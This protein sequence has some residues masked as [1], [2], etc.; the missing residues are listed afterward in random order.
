MAFD[1]EL[2]GEAFLLSKEQAHLRTLTVL[3]F[4]LQI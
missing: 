1:C 4:R 2:N 3:V